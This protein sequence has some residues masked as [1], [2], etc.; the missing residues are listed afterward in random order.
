VKTPLG[1]NVER[2][3]VLLAGPLLLCALAVPEFE[4]AGAVA[5]AAR[6]SRRWPMTIPLALALALS[7]IAVWTVWGPW[8]ETSAVA[9][10]PAITA[11]Y[12]APVE[13][14]LA[15]HGGS[16]ERVEAP[17]TR[18]HWEAAFLAENVPLARGWEKQLEERY[19]SVLLGKGLTAGSYRR[20]LDEQ[21]VAF[22]ALPDVPLDG[23]SAAEGRLIESGLPY[24]KPVFQ[25]EHWRVFAVRDPT[26]LLAGPARL[27]ALGS[28][29]F[30]LDAK[31]P[32]RL[33][34]RVHYTP[35][36]E[37]TSGDA[38]VTEAPG[39]WT[40][41]DAKAAGRIAVATR[42]SVGWAFG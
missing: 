34:L 13:R 42:F 18:S 10:S 14:Y 40:Y 9:G 24:L 22:V 28:E 1:S 21:A 23:S 11:A 3:G 4:P 20:W 15:A 8:R 6:G 29:G 31:A 2:Y 25:S 26:P 39:G 19:D 12:Y 37:V 41:V 27:T 16:L 5:A 17:L 38:S 33:L 7:A 32:A 36:F 30:A 35:Y